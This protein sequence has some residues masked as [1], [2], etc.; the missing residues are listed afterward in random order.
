MTARASTLDMLEGAA[1]FATWLRQ[2]P[3]D[4]RAGRDPTWEAFD[5][6]T[7]RFHPD[8]ET[9]A[10][11]AFRDSVIALAADASSRAA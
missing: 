4:I 9:E 1:L 10:A 5:T 3:H 11:D 6:W 2:P 7:R 8:T